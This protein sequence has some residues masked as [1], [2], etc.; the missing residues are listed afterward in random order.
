MRLCLG[1]VT[2]SKSVSVNWS[3]VIHAPVDPQSSRAIHATRCEHLSIANPD[4][5]QRSPLM[6]KPKGL[7]MT[8]FVIN[9]A[10]PHL[11]NIRASLI[12]HGH[13]RGL[14]AL[15][16]VAVSDDAA[17]STITN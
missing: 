7:F 9:L 12:D 6:K 17:I 8:D 13:P 4:S 2:Q 5:D 15:I 10:E 16:L 1:S 14:M 3:T 11:K